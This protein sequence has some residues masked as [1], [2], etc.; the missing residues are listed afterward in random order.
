M[1]L[2][3]Q[4]LG[5]C[6]PALDQSEAHG[7]MG[8]VGSMPCGFTGSMTQAVLGIETEGC[9]RSHSCLTCAS[10]TEVFFT[11]DTVLQFPESHSPK[12]GRPESCK[13]QKLPVSLEVLFP[14]R[15]Q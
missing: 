5:V 7:G 11:S 15:F 2:F 8:D 12:P 14:Q 1:Y 9:L 4:R 13:V 3:S 6:H 10:N